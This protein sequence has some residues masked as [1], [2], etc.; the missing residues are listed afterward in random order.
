MDACKP[1][2]GETVR[3]FIAEVLNP[4]VPRDDA[5]GVTIVRDLPPLAVSGH[6]A[7]AASALPLSGAALHAE[8]QRLLDLGQ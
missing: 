5:Q 1:G 4:V 6:A 7:L 2:Y 8:I 3:A